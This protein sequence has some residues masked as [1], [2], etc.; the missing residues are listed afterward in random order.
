MNNNSP[1]SDT[2]RDGFGILESDG[3][4]VS[5]SGRA[6]RV[7]KFPNILTST[8]PGSAVDKAASS[9]AGRERQNRVDI[10][11]QTSAQTRLLF[12]HDSR[13][14]G[15]AEKHLIDL[16]SACSGPGV[17][18]SILCLDADFFT[19]RLSSQET[20]SL[21]VKRSG[22]P[23][24]FWGWL[25]V[26]RDIRPDAVVFVR[27]CLWT[28]P[29]YTTVAGWLAGIPR[30]FSIAHLPPPPVPARV[31]GWSMRNVARRLKRA[32]HLISVRVSASFHT[33]TICVSN[34][35][36]ESLVSD[37]GFPAKKTI[38]I[39][40][41]VSL[42]KF[43]GCANG[44]LAI[45][46]RLR[47]DSDDFLVVSIARLSEQK[48]I[49][50]LLLAMAQVLS[51]GVRCKCIIAGDGPLRAQLSAQALS[52]GLSD[53]VFFEGFQKDVR[54]YLQAADA[55]V[56]TS[57]M[58]GLPLA[59]LEAMACGLP[60]IVTNVGGN[61]EVITHRVDGLIVPPASVDEVA[62]AISHLA[63]HPHDCAEMSR[64]A[65]TRVHE[66]FDLKE[67]M[68]EIKRVILS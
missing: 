44:Q 68:G 62:A 59:I 10:G 13:E 21:S 22:R 3:D 25:Q 8:R 53:H 9:A 61:T 32:R 67:K 48:G 65:R 16:I 38:T 20:A 12:I 49:D 40:N 43:E 63:T 11:P 64:R 28:F 56:L 47:V 27:G 29:W 52:L 55:F 39:H 24:S 35:I 58:E 54:P 36:R 23:K 7:S 51:N 26:L 6:R 15:G 14:Y 33:T 50:V 30:R 42:S 57:H 4:G 34:A 19:E 18:L 5:A 37:Y 2:S 1:V 17:G 66:S 31:K 60:C 45:R 41:G 46:S